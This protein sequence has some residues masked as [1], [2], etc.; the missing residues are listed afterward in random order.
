MARNQEL[1]LLKQHEQKAF[2]RKQGLFQKYKEVRN[3]VDSAYQTMQSVWSE[4]SAARER[5]NRAYETMKNSSEHYK[6]VWDDY[7]RIRNGNNAR[8]EDLKREADREYAEMKDCFESA[9]DAY[10]YGNKA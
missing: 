3:K 9:S 4:C 5:M 10:S 2:E 1:D 8:I 6:R 7:G